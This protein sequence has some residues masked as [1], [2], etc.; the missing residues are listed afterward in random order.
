MKSNS[1]NRPIER[2]GDDRLKLMIIEK[3]IGD[4][5][6]TLKELAEIAQTILR[7]D[8]VLKQTETRSIRDYTFEIRDHLEITL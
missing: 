6:L 8:V 3:L 2:A 4:N 7:R 5:D 1:G